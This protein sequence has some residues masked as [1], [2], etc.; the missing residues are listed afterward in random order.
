MYASYRFRR[1]EILEIVQELKPEIEHR[2]KWNAP[3]SAE[4]QVLLALRVY[5]TGAFQ[6]LLGDS[7]GVRKSTASRIIS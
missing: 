5:A 2:T 3:I 6:N 7:L 4:N 1:E